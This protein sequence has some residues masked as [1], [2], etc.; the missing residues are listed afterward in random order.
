MERGQPR[1]TA[2]E[3]ARK[4]AQLI[5]NKEDEEL[6]SVKRLYDNSRI[7]YKT[8]GIILKAFCILSIIFSAIYIYDTYSEVQFNKFEV[9]EAR[10]ETVRLVG[11]GDYVPSTWYHVQLNKENTFE[12]FMYAREY[13]VILD[14]GYLEIGHTAIFHK[15]YFFKVTNNE[16]S[17]TK[18]IGYS[19]MYTILYPFTLLLICLAWLFMKPEKSHS[20]SIYGYVLAFVAPLLLFLLLSN[21]YT[22][23]KFEGF[24]SMP[25]NSIEFKR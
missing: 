7:F 4:K 6:A 15:P 11:G 8:P 22:E 14:S 24:H 13:E 10:S 5:K 9:F 3:L 21:A 1:F 23:Y 18:P 19:Y 25:I 17:Y 20:V 2:E 16:K 12:V